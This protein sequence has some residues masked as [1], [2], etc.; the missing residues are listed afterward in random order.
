MGNNC[1]KMCTPSFWQN[2]SIKSLEAHIE[3]NNI[4]SRDEDGIT[5]LHVA[6]GFGTSEHILKLLDAG[7][8]LNTRTIHGFSPLHLAAAENASENITTLLEAGSYV[9]LLSEDNFTPLHLAAAMGAV[10]SIKIFLEYG[11]DID[12]LTKSD[13]TPLHRAARAKNE[14]GAL[15]LIEAGSKVNSRSVYDSIPLHNAARLGSA[16]T[17]EILLEAGS[18]IDVNNYFDET[19]LYLA[20]KSGSSENLDIL[21]SAGAKINTFHDEGLTPIHKAAVQGAVKKIKL[22]IAA[23]A[24]INSIDKGGFEYTPLHHASEF[25]INPEAVILLL[26]AGASISAETRYGKTA[27]DL[28]KKNHNLKNTDAFWKLNDMTLNNRQKTKL[29]PKEIIEAEKGPTAESIL[30]S[31][32]EKNEPEPILYLTPAQK[33]SFGNIIRNKMRLCWNPPVGVENGLT[34]LMIL[35][36]KFDIDGKLVESPVNLTPDSGVGSLQAFE[37]ARRAVIRCS[38]YNE[39][40]PEIYEGWKEL[41]LKFNPKNMGR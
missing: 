4:N 28:I 21:L 27:L 1:S 17:I 29:K 26:D 24:D 14:I 3:T 40:D 6:S 8:S 41:N 10:D 18:E 13:E 31:L 7:A 30:E 39:L 11:A 20:V 9:D 34:N 12:A 23:G 32:K 38:P 2:L 19:P 22:L 16:K 5:P 33:E 37:A 25:S 35:G 36:L 15:M